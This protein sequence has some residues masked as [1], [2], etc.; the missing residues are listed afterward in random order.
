[1]TS[2]CSLVPNCRTPPIHG[3]TFGQ[4]QFKPEA[5]FS[6]ATSA[7]VQGTLRIRQRVLLPHLNLNL[8]GQARPRRTGDKKRSVVRMTKE[9]KRLPSS[10]Q[11]HESISGLNDRPG[12]RVIQ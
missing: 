12:G 8:F 4:V 2:H 1:M 9:Q 3:T 5:T 10:I 6:V 11:G 7:G